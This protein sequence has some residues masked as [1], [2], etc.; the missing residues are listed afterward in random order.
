MDP[1]KNVFRCFLAFSLFCLALA[2][3]WFSYQVGRFL[4]GFPAILSQM[5]TTAESIGPVVK[6]IA[7]TS[8]NLLP[9][10]DNIVL[11][12]ASLPPVVA[13]IQ[14]VRE[15]LPGLLTQTQAVA[16]Q[17]EKTGKP[18]SDALTEV[19]EVRKLIPDALKTLQ[20][21]EGR[22][23]QLLAELERYRRLVPGMMQ[24]LESVST[25]LQGLNRELAAIRPLIPKVL[26]EVE[27]TRQSLPA[28][29]DQAERIA[30]SGEDFGAGA[31]RGVVTGL[32]SLL[33]P[34]AITAQLKNLVLPGRNAEGLTP[35]DIEMIRETTLKIVKTGEAGARLTWSNKESR[36]R[37]NMRVIRV[38]DDQGAKC[39]ELVT[40]IW[41]K[42]DK[43]HDFNV[44][45][46]QQADGSWV[47]LGR[48][49]SNKNK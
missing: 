12:A 5:E 16:V 1:F 35:A 44:V 18:L 3:G 48:P 41:V 4:T 17:L 20:A 40:E 31:G 19:R 47:D 23:P 43:T 37:G 42:N 7:D 13:E 8:R 2:L 33:N 14:A 11:T 10:S 27:S 15:S 34:L 36:N 6:D 38:F 25:A 24:S 9:I 49:V 45:F 32:I 28:M 46:C 26:A 30:A 22:A 39:K 29:L 21:V